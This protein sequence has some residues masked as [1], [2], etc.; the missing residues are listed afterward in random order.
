MVA[1]AT[2]PSSK[3]TPRRA[4]VTDK[5]GLIRWSD[6]HA[7]AWIGLLETH[8]RLT[9]ELET[10]LE[11]EYGLG[12]SGLELL[13]RLGRADGRTLR[14]TALAEQAGLSLSRVS[15]VVDSLES[16]GLVERR[17][18]TEDSRAKDARLTAEGLKLLREAL[19]TH[20]AGVER[21]FFDELGERDIETLARVFTPFRR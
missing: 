10:E 1:L 18:S 3:R 5:D 16:R 20:F 17:A 2:M 13:S 11:A 12:I 15:R 6:T 4:Y 7:A 21:L 14:L 19:R 8:K 9:R